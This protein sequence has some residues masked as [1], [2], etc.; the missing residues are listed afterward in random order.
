MAL[1]VPLSVA[2]LPP[3]STRVVVTL[4]LGTMLEKAS[5]AVTT[6]VKLAA[7]WQPPPHGEVV[8]LDVLAL[9]AAALTVMPDWVP[10]TPPW[11]AVMLFEPAVLRVALKVWTPLSLPPP[12]VNV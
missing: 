6:A 11:V 3:P 8:K 9:D 2:P 4:T 10:V 1:V 12:V 7:D 5:L